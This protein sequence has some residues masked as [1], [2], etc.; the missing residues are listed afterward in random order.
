MINRCLNIGINGGLMLETTTIASRDKID[1]CHGQAYRRN[2][3]EHHTREVID[4]ID[5]I[6]NVH[7]VH[8]LFIKGR[9]SRTA[10]TIEHLND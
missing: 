7:T 3:R 10:S 4:E 6:H 8:R 5:D 2:N 1:D 9:A